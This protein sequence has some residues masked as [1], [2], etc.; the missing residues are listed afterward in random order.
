MHLSRVALEY[1]FADFSSGFLK[2]Q[3]RRQLKQAVGRKVIH[4]LF[5]ARM[6]ISDLVLKAI[7]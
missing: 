4:F 6:Q 7:K 5:S 2:P 1:L 3:T